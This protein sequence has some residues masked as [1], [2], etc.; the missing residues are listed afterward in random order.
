MTHSS[1]DLAY[2]SDVASRAQL[3]A[4]EQELELARRFRDFRDQ[5]AA[6]KLVRCHF[7]M[8]IAMALKYRHY[9]IA[10]AD[11]VAEGN[12]GLVAAL[13]RFDPE[14]GHRFATYAQHWVR[15]YMLEHVAR[16]CRVA[17]SGATR[18]RP[19]L[20][21]KLRRERARVATLMGVSE[22]AEEALAERMSLS[23]SRLRGLLQRLDSHDVTVDAAPDGETP[24]GHPDLLVSEETPEDFYLRDERR[25][26]AESVV[27]SALEVLDKRESYIAKNRF[28]ADSEMSLA[29]I[30]RTLGISRE[31]AR[32]LES[33]AKR[34]LAS[35]LALRKSRVVL[36]L[37][38]TQREP[39]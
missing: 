34:K 22:G 13:S 33:R 10:P 25:A 7:R 18:M 37:F 8:V 6:D 36:E 11:L 35:S 4:R 23:V 5:R 39:C 17:G 32:Q 30:G 24:G 20:F 29:E 19:S 28:M 3:L 9:G 1:R 12:C 21:F 38:A 14:R 15:A 27:S 2:L 31:R 26:I 16:S